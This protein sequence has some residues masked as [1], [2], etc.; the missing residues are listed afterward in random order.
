V[1]STWSGGWCP[2]GRRAEDGTIP[3]RYPLVETPSGAYRQRTRWNVRDS[4]GTLVLTWGA[5][6]GGTLLTVDV[7]R[8]LGK[9]HLVIDLADEGAQAAAVRAARDW[10]AAELP[11]GVLNVAGPRASEDAALYGRARAFLRAVLGGG[12]G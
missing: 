3:E 10:I 9:L 12:D 2:R 4:D 6:T 8:D 5:P 11:G 1:A 7:C